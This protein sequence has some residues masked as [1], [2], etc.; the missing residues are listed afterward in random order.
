MYMLCRNF[1]PHSVCLD[2][3]TMTLI[4]WKATQTHLYRSLHSVYLKPCQQ[5][6]IWSF[7]RDQVGAG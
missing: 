2:I 3:I 5:K 7:A 6:D 4:K 1:L